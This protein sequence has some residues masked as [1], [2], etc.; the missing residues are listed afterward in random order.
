[1]LLKKIKIRYLFFFGSIFLFIFLVSELL[2]IEKES[3]KNDVIPENI[4]KIKYYTNSD[5][6]CYK[7]LGIKEISN[8]AKLSVLEINTMKNSGS[9]FVVQHRNESTLILTNS[10]VVNN[11]KSVMLK[12]TD[13]TTD[14]G[15]VVYDGKGDKLNDLALIEINKIKGNVL[16]L[17]IE[18]L[19]I[20][21]E[22]ISVGYPKSLGFSITRGIIS[23]LRSDNKLVQTDAA[24]NQGN[25]GGPL[26]DKS[27]CVVG[28]NTFI[29]RDAEGLNFAIS[30]S[31]AHEF[32]QEFIKKPKYYKLVKKQNKQP[33]SDNVLQNI[34]KKDFKSKSKLNLELSSC[35]NNKINSYNFKSYLYLKEKL[36]FDFEEIDSTSKAK[37]VLFITCQLLSSTFKNYNFQVFLKRGIALNT[38]G[39]NNEAIYFFKKALLVSKSEEDLANVYYEKARVYSDMKN[40]KKACESY[41]KSAGF[42]YEMSKSLKDKYCI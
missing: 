36:V 10:H 28:I 3:K 42:G 30:G 24:I 23:A 35:P 12:W 27:G 20:G 17:K 11:N 5:E 18:D 13:G 37:E 7:D 1:M 41:N 15:Q 8:I 32:I 14:V 21:E 29:F 38:L 2:K 31:H 40:N 16:K 22:V 39:L 26:I 19:S 6:F 33:T 34:P 4:Q 9:G 25:S